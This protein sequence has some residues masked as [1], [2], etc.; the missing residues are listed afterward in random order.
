MHLD[1]RV[2]SSSFLSSAFRD[3]GLE[4]EDD[5][6]DDSREENRMPA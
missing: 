5:N 1:I 6:E 2:W 3:C 4:A